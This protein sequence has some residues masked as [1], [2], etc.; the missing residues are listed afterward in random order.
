MRAV[1]RQWISL[2]SHPIKWFMHRSY[3]R[4]RVSLLILLGFQYQ[5]VLFGAFNATTQWDV[6]T[7]G[8]DTN[9]GAFDPG[10]ASPGTDESQGSGT[11][12]TVTATA[13]TGTGSPAFTSTTHGPG[14][15]ISIASGAGCNTGTFEILSQA[16]GVATFDKSM[17]TGACVGVIGG[18]LLT[19]DFVTK[20]SAIFTA[21]NTLNIKAG[22]YSR[23]TTWI[24]D[25][26]NLSGNLTIIGYQ[27]TH[28]DGGTK[29]LITTATNSNKLIQSGTAGSYTVVNMSFSNTA[30]VRADGWWFSGTATGLTVINCLFDGFVVAL[31]GDNGAGG[32][33][34]FTVWGTE[35][36]NSTSDGI[37]LWFRSSFHG[38]YIHNNG[39]DGILSETP[40]QTVTL[41]RT[42]LS[43][44]TGRGVGMAAANH[45]LVA[46]NSVFANNTSDGIGSGNAADSIILHNC[47][48]Y[49]NGGWGVNVAAT[50]LN[51][52]NFTLGEYNAFGGPNVSG[53][54]RGTYNQFN[55]IALSA[56]P[57][58]SSTNF[59][60]NSTAGGGA[61]LKQA[62]FPG[63]FPGGTST[64]YLD[65]GAVQTSGAPGTGG[66]NAAFAQ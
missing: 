44:N 15:F 9:G 39:G 50:G 3:A 42:I 24:I 51:S 61:A 65:I 1:L 38:S 14:N 48:I 52:S 45:T 6:R 7:T 37:R 25:T 23:T 28:N 10:V 12:I 40:G 58:V 30:A 53:N 21:G 63:V 19:V 13:T 46:S 27:T 36:K 20:N 4:C 66:S 56:N 8:L 62:G 34:G 57:F 2:F 18:S 11:A 26:S 60:L 49:A 54:T 47:I 59:A 32:A 35:V 64:G 22:T 33:A 43:A 31:N 5:M 55:Q 16:A 41:S 17:G 29:P